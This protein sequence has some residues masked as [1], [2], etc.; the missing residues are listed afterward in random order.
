MQSCGAPGER[1]RSLA[2]EV[3]SSRYSTIWKP[4]VSI[5]LSDWLVYKYSF[6]RAP[7]AIR[8]CLARLL[9]QTIGIKRERVWIK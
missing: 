1:S 5:Q 4:G 7:S 2:S 6:P 3:L 8:S 9:V